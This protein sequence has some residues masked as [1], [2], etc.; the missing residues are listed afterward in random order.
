MTLHVRP[1]LFCLVNTIP[2]PPPLPNRRARPSTL[3]Q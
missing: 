3:A 2:T 1:N